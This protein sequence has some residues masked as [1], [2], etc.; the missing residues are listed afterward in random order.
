MMRPPRARHEAILSPWLLGRYLATGLYVGFATIGSFVW[1]Y[2]DQGASPFFS[3]LYSLFSLLSSLTPHLS[4]LS[5]CRSPGVTL[6]QLTRWGACQSWPDFTHS[7]EAPVMPLKPCDIFT[8]GRC[9]PQAMALSV[10]VTMEMLKALSAVSLDGSMLRVPPWRN[11]WLLLGVSVPFL[12]HLAVLYVPA[13]AST[14]GL[15]PLSRREWG[16][17]LRFALPILLLEEGLK[18]LA[19]HYAEVRAQARAIKQQTRQSLTPP[20]ILL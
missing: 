14:F 4:S 11:R 13:L 18:W 9:R 20:I 2:L 5:L 19:R 1:W 17:I 3:L 6:G 7:A 15:A 12:L 10:L 8:L 16:V